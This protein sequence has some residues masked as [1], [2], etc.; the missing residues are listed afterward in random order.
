MALDP[1][2]SWHFVPIDRNLIS[3]RMLLS[4]TLAPHGLG[5]FTLPWLGS[6]RWMAP[7][8]LLFKYLFIYF[9]DETHFENH[10]KREE[11]KIAA[12]DLMIIT[13]W[14]F[15]WKHISIYFTICCLSG[16]LMTSPLPFFFHFHCLAASLSFSFP[17]V[18]SAVIIPLFFE[19]SINSSPS[20]TV[21]TH[22]STWSF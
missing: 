22:M 14:L 1:S 20:K 21:P 2:F 16:P 18:L 9:L 7:V 15:L 11:A 6:P 17:L 4:A 13:D 8:L 10:N 5:F 3:P 12:S 19:V